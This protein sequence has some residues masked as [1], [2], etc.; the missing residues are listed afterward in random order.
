MVKIYKFLLT[1]DLQ[2]KVLVKKKILHIKLKM[3]LELNL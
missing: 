2:K 3:N 1:I